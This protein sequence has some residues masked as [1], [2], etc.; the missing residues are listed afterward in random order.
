MTLAHGEV[1]KTYIVNSL[2]M[3]NDTMRRLGALGLNRGTKV[4]LLNRNQ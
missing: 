1:G 3:D 2:G 4:K